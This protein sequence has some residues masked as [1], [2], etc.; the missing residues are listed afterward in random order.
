MELYHSEIVVMFRII[1]FTRSGFLFSGLSIFL[2]Q[3]PTLLDVRVGYF[4]KLL[5]VYIA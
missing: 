5:S 2:F 4:E 3:R 1:Y